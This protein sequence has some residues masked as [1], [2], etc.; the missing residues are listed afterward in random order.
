MSELAIL[1]FMA[2]ALLLWYQ[3][4]TV[5]EIAV[6]YCRRRCEAAGVQ[7][8]DDIAPVW[9]VRFVRDA[10]GVLRLR[11]VYTFDYSTP[12]GERRHGSVVMLG[13]TPVSLQL[14]ERGATAGARTD[15]FVP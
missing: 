15:H 1:L 9:R 4:R 11:R 10:G 6:A 13:R 5:Q 14:E 8:L 2:V 3:S 12:D 7:F